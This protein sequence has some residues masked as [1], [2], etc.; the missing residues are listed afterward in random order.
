MEILN[1]TRQTLN[2]TQQKTY[3]IYEET[4]ENKKFYYQNF[5]VPNSIFTT[6]TQRDQLTTNN[7]HSPC[8][9]QS[10]DS[11]VIITN[12]SINVH[13]FNKTAFLYSCFLVQ[14]QQTFLQLTL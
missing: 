2:S 10:F 7:H 14:E 3:C 13:L 11:C 9:Q 1:T 6:L 5:F 8:S 12:P 4:K